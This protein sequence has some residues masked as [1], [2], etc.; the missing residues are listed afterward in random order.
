MVCLDRTIFGKHKHLESEGAKKIKILRKLPFKVVQMKILA[1]YITNQKWSFDIFTVGNLQNIFME[2]DLYLIFY[3]D[4]CQNI[5]KITHI[6]DL[7]KVFFWLLLQIYP[8]YLWLLLWSRVT[9]DSLISFDDND[10]YCELSRQWFF[11]PQVF[12]AWFKC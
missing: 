11:I 7:N 9:N 5:K 3:N 1:M 12:L 4:F 2:H 6:F 10:L 8:C